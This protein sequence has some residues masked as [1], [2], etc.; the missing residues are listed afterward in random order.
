MAE[1]IVK[2]CIARN[3][4]MKRRY[5]HGESVPR[6]AR[7]YGITKMRV[8]QILDSMGCLRRDYGAAARRKVKDSESS[9]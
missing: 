1:I 3:L 6:I 5:D 9:S 8:W 4:Q 2:P 7:D